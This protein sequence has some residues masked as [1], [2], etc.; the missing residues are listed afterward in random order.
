MVYVENL[1]VSTA[2][3]VSWGFYRAMTFEETVRVSP[4]NLHM[5]EAYHHHLAGF[6]ARSKIFEG[7]YQNV[8][9]EH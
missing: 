7:V 4:G 9:H 2:E 6:W 3:G 5:P 8:H 1:A